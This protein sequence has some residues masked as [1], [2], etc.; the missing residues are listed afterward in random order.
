MF[1]IPVPLLK[2][3]DKELLPVIQGGMGVGVSAHR[4]AGTVAREGAV[5]TI[6]SIDL[7]VHHP[8]LMERTRRVRDRNVIEEANLEALDR[9]IR[10]AREIS[11][12]DGFIA[13]NVMKAVDR[14]QDLVRQAC[15][16]GANAIIMGAGLPFDLPEMIKGYED[17][18]A[19][20]PILSEERGV[21]A[22]LKRWLRKGV[23]PDAIVLEHPAF[24]GGHL[25]APRPENIKDPRFDF[26]R[27]LG[28][29]PKVFEQLKLDAIPL[30]PA[31]GVNS[32]QKIRELLHLGASG[33]QIGTPFAVTEEG[34][35]HDN[36]KKVLLEAK[37]K[38]IVTFMSTAGL[39][40]RAVLT[41]WLKKYLAREEKVRSRATPEKGTCAVWF[42]CLTH[43][44]LKDGDGSSGQF[45]IDTQL[46]AAVQGNV[47]K[48]L[49]F[50]G[51]EPL[52][53]GDQVRSVH[54][55]L[56]YLLTGNDPRTLASDPVRG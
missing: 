45:C 32:F 25:G 54:D 43:C 11:G 35:A 31:G 6:A 16:S 33:V 26:K 27:V 23:L 47:D 22:V 29:I 7:R 19:L 44:G 17:Q 42:E 21:R 12:P 9:E 41:P 13:V 50:R 5:G 14:H 48:G 56:T 49:F 55:L 39:P 15:E 20:I 52:P 8:D 38:D 36:F 10:S 4:L 24:A 18:V 1:D 30:L 37:P 2:I 46:Q 51:S 3:R 40:A 53:F 34:D 28:E